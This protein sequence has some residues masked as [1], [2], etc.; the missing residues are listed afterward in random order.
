MFIVVLVLIRWQH[1]KSVAMTAGAFAPTPN[2]VQEFFPDFAVIGPPGSDGSLS[3]LESDG[4]V[5]GFVLQT[6]PQSDHIIGFSG[7]TN[8]MVA[9]DADHRVLGFATISSGDT[10]DHLR[11]VLASDRFM[12]SLNGMTSTQIVNSSNVDAVSGATLTSFAIRQSIIDRLGGQREIRSLKFP[13]PPTLANVAILFPEA[14]SITK[15]QGT[16]AIWTVRDSAGKSIG[17]VL[18]TSP[19]ADNIVGYQGPTE[20]FIGVGSDSRIIG[21][22]IGNS[23]DNEPYVGYVRDDDYFK[24]LFTERTVADLAMVDLESGEV[25]GVSGATMTS[26]AVAKGMVFAAKDSQTEKQSSQVDGTNPRTAKLTA[27][28]IGTI[29]IVLLGIVIG[30]TGLR[31]NRTIRICFQLVLV[32]YL[33]MIAGNLVSQAMLVGW[34]KHGLPWHR[35]FGLVLLSFAAFAIPIA[36]RRNLYCTH[37]CPHGALQQL[38]RKR[39][40]RRS[41][42]LESRAKLFL[43]LVPAMLLLWCL[44]VAMTGLSFSLVDIE[45][46]DAYLFRVAGWA[47]IG[48][49]VVGLVASLFVPMAYCRYGCPTGALLRFLRF[50]SASDRW[51]SRD[52]VAVIYL[53]IAVALYL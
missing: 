34:A 49:A 17:T 32:L 21:I 9:F 50:N 2:R 53:G 22:A 25:E 24:S 51:S 37:L 14:T 15:Q 5:L 4:T 43:S 13:D 18:R 16:A 1:A 38:V 45:P 31:A 12:T 23:Y 27:H 6:S 39:L 40:I 26:M 33:G 20:T 46:F 7:P 3:V 8:I 44:I 10:R 42:K 11:R 47:T 28:D 41:Y 19:A 36:T 52:W 30:M 48:V 35:A 29:L